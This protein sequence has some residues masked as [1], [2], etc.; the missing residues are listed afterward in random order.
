[1]LKFLETVGERKQRQN[2]TLLNIVFFGISLQLIGYSHIWPP[3]QIQLMLIMFPLLGN[4]LQYWIRRFAVWEFLPTKL[5]FL[6]LCHKWYTCWVTCPH[7]ALCCCRCRPPGF[8]DAELPEW[9]CG[10]LQGRDSQPGK[11]VRHP[12]HWRHG[13]APLPKRDYL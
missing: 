13:M 8:S 12:D 7:L 5:S 11:R 9:V 2:K 6:S 3:T 10:S 4:S 1:M